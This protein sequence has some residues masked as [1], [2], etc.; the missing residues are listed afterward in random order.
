MCFANFFFFKRKPAY[1]VLRSLVGS[2]MCIRDRGQLDDLRARLRENDAQFAV[3]K[4]TL[5]KI[6]LD[7]VGMAVPDDLLKGPVALAVAHTDLP[8]TCLLYTSDAADDLRC[9]D[10]GGP[11]VIKK[12]K[13]HTPHS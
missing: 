6:A 9:V 7:E 10:L 8:K 1:E 3:T 12:K 11:R 4:N 5:L 2:E 13:T